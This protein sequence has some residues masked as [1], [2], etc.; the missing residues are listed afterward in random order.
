L[1]VSF[2]DSETKSLYETE[3]SSRFSGVA[4][5]ALRKLIQLNEADSLQDMAVPPGNRLEALKG[6]RKGL[7]SIRIIDQW[8]ICFRWTGCDAS[9]VEICD[10]H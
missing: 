3:R 8:R 4:R 10:Y 1:I 5:V 7:F 6:N 9:E 2:K